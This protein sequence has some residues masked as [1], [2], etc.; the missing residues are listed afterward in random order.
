MHTNQLTQSREHDDLEQY[1]EVA[2]DGW[3]LGQ[4]DFLAGKDLFFKEPQTYFEKAY[5]LGYMELKQAD[6]CEQFCD[7]A[8]EGFELGEWDCLKGKEMCFT[9]PKT[10]FEK[11]YFLGYTLTKKSNTETEHPET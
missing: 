4:S 10:Y 7:I 11:G 5:C 2:I 9:D 6:D 3:K 1:R 8:R